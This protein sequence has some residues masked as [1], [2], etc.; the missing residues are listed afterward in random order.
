VSHN[1]AAVLNLCTEAILLS[2]GRMGASG[3]PRA[4]V[5]EYLNGSMP[6]NGEAYFSDPCEY[7]SDNEFKFLAVRI[8]NERGQPT[9]HVDLIKGCRIEIEYAVHRPITDLQV[10]F[11]LW[12]SSGVCILCTTNMDYDPERRMTVSRQ[13]RYRASCQL[14]STMFRSGRYWIGL[15]ASVPGMRGL[16][17]VQPAISFDV[18]DTGSVEYR[19]AQGR[20]GVIAPLLRWESTMFAEQS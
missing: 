9:T 4:V 1:I 6:T 3:T 17:E 19:L 20:R 8:L 7:K 2:E 14:D 18:V 11:E 5:D 10:G 16:D 12:T 15:G 13:G